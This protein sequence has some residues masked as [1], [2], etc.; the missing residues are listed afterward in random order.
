M[1]LYVYATWNE[2]ALLFKGG[3]IKWNWEESK[4]FCNMYSVYQICTVNLIIPTKMKK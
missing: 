2:K 3:K 1:T 4:S